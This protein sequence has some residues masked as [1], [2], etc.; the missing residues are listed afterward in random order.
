VQ[1]DDDFYYS[2]TLWLEHADGNALEREAVIGHFNAKS[3]RKEL[4]PYLKQ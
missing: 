1:I 3:L 4:L 2:S